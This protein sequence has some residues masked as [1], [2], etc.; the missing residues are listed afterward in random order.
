MTGLYQGDFLASLKPGIESSLHHWQLSSTTR[1]SLL[2]ISENA[3]FR[4]D[5]PQRSEP[6]IIRDHRP[7]YHSSVEIRAELDWIN[8]LRA[9]SPTNPDNIRRF[10]HGIRPRWRNSI[11]S[12]F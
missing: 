7:G 3:T 4:A 12:S 2:C 11:S 8:A 10:D 6:V 9:D 1:L 5:D